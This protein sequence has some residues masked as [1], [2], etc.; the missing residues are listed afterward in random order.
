MRVLTVIFGVLFA[1]WILFS[2]GF[3]YVPCP[4]SRNVKERLENNAERFNVLFGQL[5]YNENAIVKL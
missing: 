1:T 4:C 5:K 3:L 2:I